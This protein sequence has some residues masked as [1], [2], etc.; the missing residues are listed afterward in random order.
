MLGEQ[1]CPPAVPSQECLARVFMS[2]EFVQIILHFLKH[3]CFNLLCVRKDASLE[4]HNIS[5]E[6]MHFKITGPDELK[7]FVSNVQICPH[8][9]SNFGVSVQGPGPIPQELFCMKGMCAL[10]MT[11]LHEFGQPD[12]MLRM[13]DA[14]VLNSLATSAHHHVT[15]L[16][17]SSFD[18]KTPNIEK[19]I[20]SFPQLKKLVLHRIDTLF[21]WNIPNTIEQ[22]TVSDCENIDFDLSSVYFLKVKELEIEKMGS[23]KFDFSNCK[24]LE[25]LTICNCG[26]LTYIAGLGW[27]DNLRTLKIEWC[28]SLSFKVLPLQQLID[29]CTHLEEVKIEYKWTSDLDIPGLESLRELARTKNLNF[30]IGTYLL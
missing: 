2:W 30:E 22:L 19:A 8:N 25:V 1:I 9:I 28:D 15:A 16:R 6:G 29:E 12:E 10:D 21:E 11:A 13:K 23:D 7:V 24:E 14:E 26:S 27:L 17:L 4:K 18:C 3:E 20:Q 5:L